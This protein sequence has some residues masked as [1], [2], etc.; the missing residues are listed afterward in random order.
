MIY[1]LFD[2]IEDRKKNPRP[3]SYTNALLSAGQDKILQKV[4]EECTELIIAAANQGERRIIEEF[5]DLIYHGLVLL[6][7][8]DIS[9]ADVENELQR[10][11]L[12]GGGR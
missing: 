3:N 2:L 11:H 7:A 6:A 5:A 10:R 1:H 4:G 8:H 9:L 12:E